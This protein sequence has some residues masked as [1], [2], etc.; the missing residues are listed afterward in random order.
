MEGEVWTN[1]ISLSRFPCERHLVKSL[2]V[3]GR[4]APR[5]EQLLIDELAELGHGGEVVRRRLV[6]LDHQ[7]E[8]GRLLALVEVDLVRL[9]AQEV[10][11]AVTDERPVGEVDA[12]GRDQSRFCSGRR[13]R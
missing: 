5:R 1:V 13:A 7:D 9:L 6:E 11:V 10:G 4:V 8:L 2:V 12:W 3:R